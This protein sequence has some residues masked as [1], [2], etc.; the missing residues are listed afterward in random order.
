MNFLEAPKTRH[1]E[2]NM[3]PLINIVF[4]LLI[5]FILTSTFRTVDPIDHQIPEASSGKTGVVT[6]AILTLEADGAI[7]LDGE[8]F[9]QAELGS[10]LG[11]MAA[12]GK[13]KLLIK[14]AQLASISMLRDVMASAEAAGFGE[15]LLATR[16]AS[17]SNP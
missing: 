9:T 13:S 4:L 6:E 10:V 3:I 17:A 14:V 7:T 8:P 15:I 2:I 5:F 11:D 12:A 16:R 1:R